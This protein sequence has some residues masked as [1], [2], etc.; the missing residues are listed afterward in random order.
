MKRLLLD[1]HA[2]LWWLMDEGENRLGVKAKSYVA[3]P[4]N[5]V[6]VS[7]VSTWEIAL[8]KS[9]G[10]LDA[11]EDLDTI[12]EDEGFIRLPITLFHGDQMARLPD[13]HKDPFDRMLIVQA[14]VE[15]LTIVTSD[16]N[17]ARYPVPI[18]AAAL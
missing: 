9:L 7:A 3:D 11:P 4:R 10:K 5:Q 18:L 14:Q 6:F 17:I 15:G 1:T 2:L 8:K 16:R 13:F 12:V